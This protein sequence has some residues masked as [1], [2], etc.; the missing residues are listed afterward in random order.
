[1][2]PSVKE[3]AGAGRYYEPD[4]EKSEYDPVD[5]V[6]EATKR[7]ETVDFIIRRNEIMNVA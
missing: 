4:R 6:L 7:G 5:E 2:L 3:Y 1:M